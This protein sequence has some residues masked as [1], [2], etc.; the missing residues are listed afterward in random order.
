MTMRWAD[1]SLFAYTR[2]QPQRS[3]RLFWEPISARTFGLL[4]ANALSNTFAPD[5]WRISLETHGII[6]VLIVEDH[7]EIRLVIR[8]VLKRYPNLQVVGEAGDGAEGVQ[9]VERLHPSLVLMDVNMP[10]M[11]GVESTRR[12]KDRYPAMVIVGLTVN[13]E[14][15][16]LA[17]MQQAGACTIVNKERIF[18]DIDGAIQIATA[19]LDQSTSSPLGTTAPEVAIPLDKEL[20]R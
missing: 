6:R 7:P 8:S 18:E 20:E 5:T 19:L 4:I 10:R 3:K 2:G 12:I 9:C 13:D 15:S 17:L 11:N 1:V 16:T 14:P